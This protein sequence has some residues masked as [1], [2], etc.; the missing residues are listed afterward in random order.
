MCFPFKCLELILF[1]G[2][3]GKH[4]KPIDFPF[5]SNHASRVLEIATEERTDALD[6]NIPIPEKE[7]Q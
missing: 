1:L 6:E 3:E 4:S 2:C 7:Y 5:L